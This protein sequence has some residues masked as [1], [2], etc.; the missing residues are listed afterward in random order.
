M[1]GIECYLSNLYGRIC[2]EIV[3]IH[4]LI[5]QYVKKM[6]QESNRTETKDAETVKLIVP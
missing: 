5:S 3:Q 4:R 2:I 6:T 1:L